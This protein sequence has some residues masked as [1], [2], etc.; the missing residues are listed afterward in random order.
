MHLNDRA[1][2]LA[3]ALLADAA[4][5]SVALPGDDPT[6]VIDCGVQAH[7]GLEAGRRLAEICL[8]GLGQVEL[9]AGPADLWQGPW[10]TVRTDHPVAACLASQYA[11]WAIGGKDYFAMGSGPMRAAYGKE[12]LFGD[13]GLRETPNVAVGVLEASAL[14]P[15]E[16][17]AEIA[18]KCGVAVEALT[19]LVAPTNSLAGCVQIAARSVETALHKLHELKFDLTR[20]VSGWGTAPLPPVAKNAL[21]G[22]GR[23]NDAILYGAHAVLYVRG[24]DESL[25]D[26]GA[27]LP[28]SSSADHGRPF[29]D[30]FKAYNH[31]FYQV[32][33]L[34]FSPA[35]IT[36]NNIG[37]GRVHR[38]GRFEPEVLKQSFGV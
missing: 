24:D 9:G 5:L 19:L 6:P 4:A 21:A 38:F 37:T 10:V 1:H 36:L 33:K 25:A 23:T 11:G 18:T 17:A 22:I 30:I 28:S 2:R 34:L 31:D 3:S 20:I 32:D 14:P 27:K 15:Q 26:V 29:A 13:I 12:E 16:V 7:G 8:A 35:V